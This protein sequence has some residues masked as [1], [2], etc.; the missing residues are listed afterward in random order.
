MSKPIKIVHVVYALDVGG[1]EN[2]LVNIVNH[3][4]DRF[5]HT[6]M[7]LRRSGRMAERINN[8]H[9]KI[10][11]MHLPTDRFCFPVIRLAR[12]FQRVAPD[13]VH[14][15]GWATVDAIWG[16]R[17]AGVPYLIHGEHGRE[18]AD[19]NGRSRKRNLVRKC[20]SPLVHQF[21]TVSDDLK[22]WLIEAVGIPESKVTTIHNGVDTG[23][24]L[25]EEPSASRLA[26]GLPG[27]SFVIGSVGRLDPVK[28]HSSLLRAFL[29]VARSIQAACL[30]I[31]GDGLMRRAIETLARELGISAQV[32]LLGERHDIPA[33][34]KACDVFALT[35]IAE[36][37][38]NTI[39]EAMAW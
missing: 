35:S 24:F 3:L 34:L 8:R 29:P 38:S 22:S 16:A 20:V 11:E 10:I 23:R 12:E 32:R 15:R 18:A 1:L 4:D 33:V 9:V 31:V 36:G 21:I 26:L 39:L 19:P 30:I 37:I 5:E 27:G 25:P 6:I 13:I 7:C 2:G 17:V 28:D 14:T